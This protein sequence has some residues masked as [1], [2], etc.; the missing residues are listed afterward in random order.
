[1]MFFDNTMRLPEE[2]HDSKLAERGRSDFAI[3]AD[4]LSKELKGRDSMLGSDFSGAYN[5]VGH[6]CFMAKHIGL[7][8]DY[9]ILEAIY[10]RL[11]QRPGHQRAYG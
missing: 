10:A 1:M 4:I 11:E 5:L 2:Q 7:I 8:G 6:S 3:R 9:P